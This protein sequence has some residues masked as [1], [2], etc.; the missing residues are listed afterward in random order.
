[1][2][3]RPQGRL[4][5]R[6]N[7]VLFQSRIGAEQIVEI[8]VFEGKALEPIMMRSVW[9]RIE[10]W[11]FDECQSM[12]RLIIAHPCRFKNLAVLMTAG[13]SA[14]T[15]EQTH[16]QH[17]ALPGRHGIDRGSGDA[18]VPRP[19]MDDRYRIPSLPSS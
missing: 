2:T 1:M 7:V 19:G 8:P 13:R 5:N 4:L 6:Q 16:T 14:G 9:I 17:V 11:Q 15:M 10:T 12:V 3:L 18:K